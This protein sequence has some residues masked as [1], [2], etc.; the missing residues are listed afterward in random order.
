MK[1][2]DIVFTMEKA[3]EPALELGKH[4]TVAGI[5]A[6]AVGNYYLELEGLEQSLFPEEAFD[7]VI[8]NVED[9]EA[10][11]IAELKVWRGEWI[12]AENEGDEDKIAKAKSFLDFF[13]DKLLL[14][15]RFAAEAKTE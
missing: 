3:L 9:P 4:Y 12:Q 10:A 13:L 6:D 7:V 8:T 14:A 11:I 2:N 5:H 1:V 15:K